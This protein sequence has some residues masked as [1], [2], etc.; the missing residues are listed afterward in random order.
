MQWIRGVWE[1]MKYGY[2]TRMPP[3]IQRIY[4]QALWRIP[5]ENKEVF[6]TFDDGP[7]PEITPWVLDQLDAFGAKAIFFLI[8][9]NVHRYPEVV[10]EI[11]R[12]GHQVGNHTMKHLD[13]WKHSPKELEI[14]L[15]R[16]KKHIPSAIFRP[17]YG[18]FRGA[19]IKL[20]TRYFDQVILWSVLSGDFDTRRAAQSCVDAVCKQIKSGDIVVFHDSDKAWPRL[21]KAL[22]MILNDLQNQGY[23]FSAIL[24]D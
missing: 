5:T 20:W 7:H 17:P 16:S 11:L 10:A 22:P 18:H 6:L 24:M 3:F 21:S 19:S 23:R 9:D 14:D 2:P 1:L 13:A 4:P 15:I 12:R 8:G